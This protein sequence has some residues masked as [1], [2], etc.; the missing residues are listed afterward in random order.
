MKRFA[1]MLYVM[2]PCLYDCT[3]QV[4]RTK[5]LYRTCMAYALKKLVSKVFLLYKRN[6]CSSDP[7]IMSLKI[8]VAPE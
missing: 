1:L 8:L 2:L 3:V 4:P 6:H 7:I 5:N